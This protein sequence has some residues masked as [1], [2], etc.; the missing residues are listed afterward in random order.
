MKEKAS[1]F[2]AV[3]L[4]CIVS[5]GFAGGGKQSA[6]GPAVNSAAIIN[7]PG[8]LPLVNQPLTLTIGMRTDPNVTDYNNNY[9]TKYLKEKTGIT[10]ELVFFSNNQ[11]DA[12][13]QFQLMVSSNEKLPDIM[14]VIPPNWR[15]LGD[16]GVFID[17][18]PYFDKYSYFFNERLKDIDPR[19]QDLIR[20]TGT[21]ASGKRY[22]YVTFNA[23]YSQ[24]FRS[25]NFI[26]KVWLD[27]LGLKMPATTDEFYN[28]LVA[29]RDRDPNGNG[30][31]D[32]IPFIGTLNAWA[33]EPL[34]FLIN[35]FVYYPLRVSNQDFVNATNGKIWTAWTTEEYRDALR[36][37]NKL[38]REGLIAPS[39][40]TM[41]QPELI[42]LVAYAEGE[43][44]TVGFFAAHQNQVLTPET[45]AIY[46]YESQIALTGPKG[47]GWYPLLPYRFDVNTFITKDCAY[48]EAAFRYLDFLNRPETTMTVRYGEEGVDWRWVKPEEN[49]T[50]TF[51]IPST[52][53]QLNMLWAT[54]Q[55]KHWQIEF[56]TI[57][58]ATTNATGVWTDTGTWS[59]S[60]AKMYR[61]V[62]LNAG[63]DA[64]ERVDFIVYT[65]AEEDEI[66]EMRNSIQ[67]YRAECLSLFCTGAMNLDRD[68]NT[69][70][71][72]LDKMGLKRY[73]EVVQK[74]Y[75]RTKGK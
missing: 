14:T 12:Q 58:T 74:A 16:E 46:D 28:T 29:F 2:L 27:K 1:V 50:D 63:K 33:S 25:N 72:E 52:Y 19:D 37:I 39:T 24:I 59:S 34:A 9:L 71:F 60:R 67:T 69:Y 17:L 68:W 73:M 65:Q 3:F 47:Q 44:P 7:A 66:R 30:K 32:E 4:L 45:P 70:L 56:G 51:N 22:A 38:Y 40:F 31:K 42:P 23:L 48:P 20:M 26:N 8:Q 21:A 13:T 61:G 54:P 11:N 64:A 53:A 49:L 36:Y 55:N 6:S 15:E 41:T 43:T 57:Y 75:T 18:Q 10:S 62:A 5:F 35:P